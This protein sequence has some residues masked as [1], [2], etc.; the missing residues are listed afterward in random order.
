MQSV[1]LLNADM[2]NAI[3]LSVVYAGCHVAFE[4][5]SSLVRSLKGVFTI[6]LK[7]RHTLKTQGN[8]YIALKAGPYGEFANIFSLVNC[9]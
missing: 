4:R 1:F 8:V 7:A 9:I 3:T 6:A 2:L 5:C